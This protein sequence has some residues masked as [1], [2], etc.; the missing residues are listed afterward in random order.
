M[1]LDPSAFVADPELVQALWLQSTPVDCS[2]DRLL[3]RQGE[4]ANGLYVVGGGEAT[5]TMDSLDGDTIL[6]IQTTAGSLLG[7]P[8]LVGGQPY[9]LTAVARAGAKIGYIGRDEFTAFMQ[10]NPTQA[11]KILQVLAAEVSAARRAISI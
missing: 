2:D 10:G 8:G 3:F 1:Q 4:A 11:F 5:L 7:L 9:S 6:S